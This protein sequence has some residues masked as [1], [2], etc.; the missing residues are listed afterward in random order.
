M[1]FLTAVLSLCDF[2]SKITGNQR[3]K[4]RPIKDLITSLSKLG[5]K[6]M[7]CLDQPFD[8]DV[9]QALTQVPNEEKKGL[10]IDV[11]ENG[12]L[13]GEKVIRF[14]KVIIGC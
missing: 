9:H 11:V 4:E 10:I 12:Y 8:A 1:R 2:K 5:V 13:M 3:M 14:P 6:K 7:E